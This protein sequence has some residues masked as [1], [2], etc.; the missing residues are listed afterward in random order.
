MGA[1]CKLMR[2]LSFIALG[3]AVF[4]LPW[5]LCAL[6]LVVALWV[7]SPFSEGLIIAVLGTV[8]F[9]GASFSLASTMSLLAFLAIFL[10][11]NAVQERLRS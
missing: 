10:L 1:D 4:M 6:F 11:F 7:F 2:I 8:I 9:L 5:W 3:I